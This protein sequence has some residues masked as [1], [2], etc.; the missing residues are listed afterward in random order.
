MA[1]KRVRVRVRDGARWREYVA[2]GM[3]F[4][5]EP[6]ELDLGTLHPAHQAEIERHAELIVEPIA[7]RR[8]RRRREVSDGVHDAV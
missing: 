6:I 3:T 8:R 7:P 1:R 2:A 4:T 5:R